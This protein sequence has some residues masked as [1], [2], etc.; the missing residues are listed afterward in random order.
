MK[1]FT[2]SVKQIIDKNIKGDI[3]FKAIE[4]RKSHEVSE[5]QTLNYHLQG[6]IT[7]GEFL[8]NEEKI[9]LADYMLKYHTEYSEISKEYFDMLDSLNK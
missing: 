7:R 5:I 4:I 1:Q 3:L 9:E 2:N 8:T 6:M